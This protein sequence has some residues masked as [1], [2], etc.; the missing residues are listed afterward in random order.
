MTRNNKKNTFSGIPKPFPNEPT[1]LYCEHCREPYGDD[2][3]MHFGK[4]IVR[5][6]GDEYHED[7]PMGLRGNWIEIPCQCEFC[8]KFT[9]IIIAFHKGRTF[10]Q[11]IKTKNRNND[12]YRQMNKIFTDIT[13]VNPPQQ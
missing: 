7:N 2:A 3:W 4:P 1:M 12:D 9:S 5:Y 13:R 6:V 11:S 8:W 10:I